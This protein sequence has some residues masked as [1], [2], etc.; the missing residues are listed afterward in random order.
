MHTP[1]NRLLFSE[2]TNRIQIRAAVLLFCS[3]LS[4]HFSASIGQRKGLLTRDLRFCATSLER[5]CVDVCVFNLDSLS[6]PPTQLR[7]L[8]PE[9]PSSNL[10]V[11]RLTA[12][13]ARKRA[14]RGPHKPDINSKC[15]PPKL[16]TALRY[17]RKFG[18]PSGGLFFIYFK[19]FP[20]SLS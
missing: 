12:Q 11:P 7:S 6:T 8:Y 5:V 16:I 15:L 14:R 1:L 17:T 9:K 13:H 2:W 10:I 19:M 18:A 4:S 20:I 3:F